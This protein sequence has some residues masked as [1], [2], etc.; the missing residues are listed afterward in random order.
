MSALYLW[1]WPGRNRHIGRDILSRGPYGQF[2]SRT[3]GGQVCAWLRGWLGGWRT[4]PG[5]SSSVFVNVLPLPSRVSRPG[6]A[7]VTLRA[8]PQLSLLDFGWLL[9]CNG[10]QLQGCLCCLFSH[11]KPVGAKAWNIAE[12]GWWLSTFVSAGSAAPVTH[13]GEHLKAPYCQDG[14]VACHTTSC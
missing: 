4:D 8:F 13:S 11:G 9:N 7:E 12:L 1:D 2:V 5:C 14:R 3:E 10:T 6:Q